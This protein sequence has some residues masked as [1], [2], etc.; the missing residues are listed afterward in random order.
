MCLASAYWAGEKDQPI[1]EDI[2][3]VRIV[4]ELVEME[5]LMG[6]KKVL[7]G[8]VREIDFMDSRIVVEQQAA[9]GYEFYG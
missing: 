1:L 2:A 3:D 7:E 9:P 5:T 4:G 6:E 8:R